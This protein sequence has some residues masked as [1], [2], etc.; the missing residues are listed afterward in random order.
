MWSRSVHPR[1]SAQ[2][3]EFSAAFLQTWEVRRTMVGTDWSPEHY[4]RFGDERT[5]PAIDLVSH[6]RVDEPAAVVDLGCG[7]GNSTA[8]ARRRWPDARLVGVDNSPEMI[9]A[10]KSDHPEGEWVLSSIE[11]WAPAEAFDVVFSNAALQWVPQH[12]PLIERLFAGVSRGGAFAFQ[13][14]SADYAQVR[15]LIHETA[16]DGPW[17][18]RMTGALSELTMESPAF[19]YDHL[20]PLARSIDAWETK[21]FHV[22]ESPVAIVDWISSTGL[23]PFLAALHGE[24][25]RQEFLARLSAGVAEAYAVRADG[26]VLFPFTRTFFVAYA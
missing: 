4:L 25:E 9:A 15:A 6:I 21:Y 22:M 19:Y 10:A 11:D 14:P 18:P 8:V 3:Q 20:A 17:A 5:R 2:S 16:Q 7:P 13:I 24:P 23:R 26:R 12:G 1:W